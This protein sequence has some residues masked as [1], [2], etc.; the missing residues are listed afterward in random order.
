MTQQMRQRRLSA[1]KLSRA[2][3]AIEGIPFSPFALELQNK[4]AR[5]EI[6]TEDAKRQLMEHHKAI[7]KKRKKL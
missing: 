2:V 1:V 7:A 5:G 4:W 6:S 3:N